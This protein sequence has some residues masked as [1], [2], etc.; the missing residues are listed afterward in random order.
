MPG[1]A[2]VM[3]APARGAPGASWEGD[4]ASELQKRARIGAVSYL[5]LYGIRKPG[6][7]VV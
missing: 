4:P 6:K 2:D 5:G 7:E 3:G 1:E